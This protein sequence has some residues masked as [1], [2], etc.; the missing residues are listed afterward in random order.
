MKERIERKGRWKGDDGSK[1]FVQSLLISPKNT[2]KHTHHNST[3]IKILFCFIGKTEWNPNDGTIFF[4]SPQ[5]Y[6]LHR[7]SMKEV[8]PIYSI[9]GDLTWITVVIFVEVRLTAVLGLILNVLLRL[10]MIA[11]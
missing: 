4:P 8:E 7:S 11:L 3:G 6:E 5:L 10:I 2:H 1:K 9:R